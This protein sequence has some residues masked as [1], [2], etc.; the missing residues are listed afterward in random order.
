MKYYIIVIL[1]LFVCHE[2][3]LSGETMTDN[4]LV[5]SPEVKNI[6]DKYHGIVFKDD[7]QYILNNPSFIICDDKTPENKLVIVF[8]TGLA[9]SGLLKMLYKIPNVHTLYLPDSLVHD[10]DLAY[11]KDMKQLR[12]LSLRGNG[13]IT[14]KGFKL[15]GELTNLEFLDLTGTHITNDMLRHLQGLTNLRELRLMRT[16]VTDEGLENLT[17]LKNLTRLDCFFTNVSEKGVA[18]F[19]QALPKCKVII[20]N[21]RA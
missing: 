15:I 6:M 14:E 3:C 7:I 21:P 18:K 20:G 13:D 12:S 2:V 17:T 1:M 10:E 4:S 19:N 16:T 5:I 8:D 9:G 11:L